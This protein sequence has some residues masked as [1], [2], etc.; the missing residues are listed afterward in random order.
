MIF[1]Y[2]VGMWYSHMRIIRAGIWCWYMMLENQR[3]HYGIWGSHVMFTYEY[4]IPTLHLCMWCSHVICLISICDVG[5][6]SSL[7]DVGMWCWYMMLVYD[8]DIW[9]SHVNISG[10]GIWI[11]Y[12]IITYDLARWSYAVPYM[13]ICEHYWKF[14]FCQNTVY[15]THMWTFS[16]MM[17]T[18]EHFSRW[19]VEEG[20]AKSGLVHCNNI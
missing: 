18:C 9:C 10:V 8:V 4:Q 13:I 12:M 16:Y 3:F 1:V 14:S 15:D 19:D 5:M 17:F 20:S 6:W 7:Y 2:D 11:S